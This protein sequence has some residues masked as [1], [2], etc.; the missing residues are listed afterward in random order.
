MSI[1]SFNYMN[2]KDVMI[3]PNS[4][5][6]VTLRINDLDATKR[7]N[8]IAR[9]LSGINL[10]E[11]SDLE[12]VSKNVSIFIQT[13]K[14]I[15][16]P[17]EWIKFRILVL[18]NELKPIDFPSYTQLNILLTDA[19][20]NRIKQWF[21]AKP[22]KG[23]YTDQIQLS[24]LPILGVWKF[25]AQIGNEKKTKEIEIAKYVL[26]KFDV[27][28]DSANVFSIKDGKI[29][30][31]IRAQYTY[32]KM[33]K[34]DAIISLT[35]YSTY[36]SIQFPKCVKKIQINGKGTVEFDIEKD[37]N[38]FY[39]DKITNQMLLNMTASVNENITGHCHSMSKEITIHQLRY[40]I[41]RELSDHEFKPGYPI[42][43]SVKSKSTIQNFL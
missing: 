20:N 21:N 24:S 41:E 37:L 7:H 9:G 4:T 27:L 10:T 5:N 29:R 39:F 31:I 32:G 15:Y 36:S 14:A 25:Y 13:D 17:T 16:K 23:I 3:N 30:A 18:D 19:A 22:Y 8:L 34:G 42:K 43:L 28:I 26:P 6:I 38:N 12:I 35:P 2:S 1:E 33:V 40:K 11:I